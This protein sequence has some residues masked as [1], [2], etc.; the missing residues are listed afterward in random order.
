L[1]LTGVG[2][3]KGIEKHVPRGALP[4]ARFAYRTY[5]R[6]LCWCV[7]LQD[8]RYTEKT[9]FASLPPSYLRYRVHG[10][11]NMNGFLRVGNRCSKN[12]EAA[13]ERVGKDLDA[14]QDILDFGCGCGRTLIWFADRSQSARWHG[15]DIDAEAVSWCRS[16]LGFAEFGVNDPLP[17]LGYASEMFDFVYAISVFTHLDEDYQYRWLDELKRITRSEG[18][19]LLTVNGRYIWKNLPKEDVADIRKGGFKFI[20]SNTAKGIF[21]EWYQ[22]AYHTKQYV[23]DRYSEYFD[24]LEYIPRGMGNQDIVVLQKS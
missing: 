3:Y 13:L 6:V 2:L 5:M 20:A 15:T 8:R 18:I 1:K 14:F 9:G 19:V 24:V 17:P 22:N 21:P 11:P 10:S 12:I 7:G 16:N 23:L 4:I